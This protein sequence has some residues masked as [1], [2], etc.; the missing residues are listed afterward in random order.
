MI[1]YYIGSRYFNEK[2]HI[3]DA[4]RASI[5]NSINRRT[6]KNKRRLNKHEKM[7]CNRSVNTV[8]IFATRFSYEIC[9]AKHGNKQT[10]FFLSLL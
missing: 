9:H 3:A 2:L 7:S 4:L 8:N 6:R 5:V 1:I 10:H